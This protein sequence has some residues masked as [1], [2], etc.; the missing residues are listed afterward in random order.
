MTIKTNQPPLHTDPCVSTYCSVHTNECM[1]GNNSSE[2]PWG[3]ALR[4][5]RSVSFKSV[6]HFSWNPTFKRTWERFVGGFK[7]SELQRWSP[8]MSEDEMNPEHLEGRN[9]VFEFSPSSSFF[10][11]FLLPLCKH[12]VIPWAL[13]EQIT[14]N[15]KKN[16]NYLFSNPWK[17]ISKTL[18]SFYFITLLRVKVGGFNVEDKS[19]RKLNPSLSKTARFTLGISSIIIGEKELSEGWQLLI[20]HGPSQLCCSV[21]MFHSF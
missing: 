8:Y 5:F 4:T 11:L 15:G 7:G 18:R 13:V 2:N 3:N 20:Y 16:E 6:D 21:L 1:A 12:M 19:W 9:C 10:H 17:T 14:H